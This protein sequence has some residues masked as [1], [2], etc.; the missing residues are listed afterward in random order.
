[1]NDVVLDVG[2]GSAVVLAFGQSGARDSAFTRGFAPM[3]RVGISTRGDGVRVGLGARYRYVAF[4]SGTP[5]EG[6]LRSGHPVL[7]EFDGLAEVEFGAD[8]V[9][10][11]FG[12]GYAMSWLANPSSLWNRLEEVRQ[13][14]TYEG[15]IL[16]GGYSVRLGAKSPL[17]LTFGL[18]VSFTNYVS[19][20]PVFLAHLVLR[21]DFVIATYQRPP[22]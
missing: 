22:S 5:S 1:M 9:G 6:N 8:G 13:P 16:D 21:S 11:R 20:P 12:V 2:V 3:A 18:T 17:R 14:F 10:P 4:W 7:H 19:T 15:F